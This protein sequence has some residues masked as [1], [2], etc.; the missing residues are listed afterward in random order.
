VRT[1]LDGT[2]NRA[3]T[4]PSSEREG[5]RLVLTLDIPIDVACVAVGW[6]GGLQVVEEVVVVGPRHLR[7]A[8]A[9]GR[10]WWWWNWRGGGGVVRRSERMLVQTQRKMFF[11]TYLEG[12]VG[13]RRVFA[14]G[15]WRWWWWR[16]R[17]WWWWRS[18]TG[19][20]DTEF[21]TSH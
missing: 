8:F 5:G 20:C 4:G 19:S 1:I 11:F 9:Q 15:R 21:K 17:W 3:L 13:L 14:R 12:A 16:W 10:W 7:L 18:F 6:T 2:P